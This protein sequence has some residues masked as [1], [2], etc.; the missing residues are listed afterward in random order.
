VTA[1]GQPASI[2]I[3]GEIPIPVP[4]AGVGAGASI[5]IVYKQFG[6]QLTVLPTVGDNCEVSMQV[7]PEVSQL[8]FANGIVLSGFR[9]PALTTRRAESTVHVPSGCS[10]AIGGLYATEDIKST[11]AIPLLSKIPVLGNF[12]KSVSTTKKSSELIIVITPEI[13]GAPGPADVIRDT[14]VDIPPVNQPAPAP[15][16]ICPPQTSSTEPSYP[17]P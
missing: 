12:F 9:V 14:K 3:G 8:D 6:I 5:T 2:L 17:T 15:A 4:Q 10:I 1:S 13:V 11:R 16:P 7:K